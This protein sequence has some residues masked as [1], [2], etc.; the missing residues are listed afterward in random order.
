MMRLNKP[1]DSELA[2]PTSVQKTINN[3]Y[4][5]NMKYKLNLQRLKD[6]KT[7]II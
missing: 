7:E 1:I 4:S 5:F 6:A 2:K 3:V